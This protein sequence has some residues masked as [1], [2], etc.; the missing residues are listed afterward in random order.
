[1]SVFVDASGIEDLELYFDRFP[2]VTRR[3]MSR[4]LN[5][6]ARDVAM[7][8][9]RRDIT[10]Q[11][12]FPEGYLDL[13]G[14]LEISRFASEDNLEVVITARDRPTSL[15]RFA[16]SG[17]PVVKKGRNPPGAGITVT[18]KPGQPQHF[19]SG[20]L[21]GLKNGNIGFAIRLGPGQRVRN[22]HTF[23]PIQIFKDVF[24]LY[25]PSVNQVF[26]NVSADIAPEVTSALE[27]EFM[28]QFV[29]L[30]GVNP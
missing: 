11:V 4:A 5:D 9:A 3:A 23:Q 24:L 26:E 30:S 6:T 15:A 16:P 1:M 2:Q 13:P 7:K 18:V 20:F 19:A 27:A 14:R 8:A 21:V 28:R 29:V 17:T 12:A 25:G 22:V 10:A